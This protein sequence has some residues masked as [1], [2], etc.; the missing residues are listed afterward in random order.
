LAVLPSDTSTTALNP[1]GD[2]LAVGNGRGEY[3]VHLWE[4]SASEPLAIVG[5]HFNPARHI[6][7][8]P[9]GNW[10]ASATFGATL[11]FANVQSLSEK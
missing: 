8:S 5:Q 4:V 11:E 7:F 6:A 3:D 10:L 1:N 9:D 2:L